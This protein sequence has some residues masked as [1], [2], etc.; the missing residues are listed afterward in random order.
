MRFPCTLAPAAVLAAVLVAAPAAAQAP[1]PAPYE[2]TKIADNVYVFRAGGYQSMFVV[3]PEGVIVA[4]L[5]ISVFVTAQPAAASTAP[6]SASADPYDAIFCSYSHKDTAIVERV[7]RAYKALG[8]DYLR[9]VT[10]LR[11]GETWNPRLLELIE[12]ADIFQLFWS[13]A[14]A[15]SR[16][17]EQEWAHALSLGRGGAFIRPVYWEQPMPKA[18]DA[19]G[20]L[21][22]HFDPALA[23]SR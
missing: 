14:S 16:Y 5:P 18:P 6:S 10:T 13:N 3:S 8:M 1:A 17:V 4:D 7:E 21:H 2:T 20:H 15:A 19:L 11:S 9:D 23:E 12:E 22:F